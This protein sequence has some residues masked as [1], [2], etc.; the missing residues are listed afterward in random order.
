MREQNHNKLEFTPNLIQ[1]YRKW[2]ENRVYV[3]EAHSGLPSFLPSKA[4][5]AGEWVSDNLKF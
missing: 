5:E 3:D 1:K 2:T 4:R